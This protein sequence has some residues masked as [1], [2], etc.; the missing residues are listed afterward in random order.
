M[1]FGKLESWKMLE[2]TETADVQ[3]SHYY[4]VDL[5]AKCAMPGGGA[6]GRVR[7]QPR[8]KEASGQV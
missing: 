5:L 8:R 1:N 6:W 2:L 4:W 3:H 7:P